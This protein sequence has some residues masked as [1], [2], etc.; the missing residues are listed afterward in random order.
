VKGTYQSFQLSKSRLIN[1]LRLAVVQ[2]SQ[3]SRISLFIAYCSGR[4]STIG[5]FCSCFFSEALHSETPELN[6][7]QSSFNLYIPYSL[8]HIVFPF[9]KAITLQKESTPAKAD[10]CFEE[11]QMMI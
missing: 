10:Y 11:A 9:M 3:V 8:N 6:Q 7:F 4:V 1:V 5:D 2:S